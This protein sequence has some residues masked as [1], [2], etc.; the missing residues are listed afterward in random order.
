MKNGREIT[1][2]ER[3]KNIYL[4]DKAMQTKGLRYT[5]SNKAWAIGLEPPSLPFFF[6][7]MKAIGNKDY[8]T[9]HGI[10]HRKDTCSQKV[11]E[12]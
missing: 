6:F 5:P 1:W 2:V 11:R 8:P 3:K 9:A 12:E 10:C 7:P 4:Y